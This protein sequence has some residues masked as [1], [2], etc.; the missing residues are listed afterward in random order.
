M[1]ETVIIKNFDFKINYDII[2]L[3]SRRLNII[4]MY[5][6]FKKIFTT[7]VELITLPL[8][9]INEEIITTIKYSKRR[10]K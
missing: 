1:T 6:L 5:V 10:L 2:I 4:K 3:E 7:K 8:F 9:L